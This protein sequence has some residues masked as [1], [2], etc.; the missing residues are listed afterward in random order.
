MTPRVQIKTVHRSWWHRG[1]V[2]SVTELYC[3]LDGETW[4]R[5]GIIL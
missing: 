5:C 1:E 4:K 2:R 3:S